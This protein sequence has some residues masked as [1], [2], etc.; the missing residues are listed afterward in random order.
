MIATWHRFEVC[1]KVANMKKKDRTRANGQ[2][3]VKRG[4]VA[5]SQS[6]RSIEESVQ[7]DAVQAAE[8]SKEIA[9]RDILGLMVP[10]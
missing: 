6:S 7:R 8:F 2:R 3:P 10:D 9:V 5:P 1:L 4:D